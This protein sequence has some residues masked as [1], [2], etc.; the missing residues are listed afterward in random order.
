[1]Q[2]KMELVLYYIIESKNLLISFLILMFV[3]G[4]AGFLA[5]RNFNQE[6]KSKI[7][8]Y[9]LFLKMNNIDI[10]KMASVIIRTFLVFYGVLVT[11]QTQIIICIIMMIIVT[12]IYIICYPKKIISYGHNPFFPV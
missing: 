4:V 9:G 2:E 1:M 3:I 10:L 7:I 11:D 5:M 12:I 6:K 8:F